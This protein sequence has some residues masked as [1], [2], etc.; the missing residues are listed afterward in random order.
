M[1][2]KEDYNNKKQSFNVSQ[3]N[4]NIKTWNLPISKKMLYIIL[5]AIF[6]QIGYNLLA[7]LF[8]FMAEEKKISE[9]TVGMIF[10][11]FAI[12]NLLLTVLTPYLT[13]IMGRQNLFILGVLIEGSCTCWFGLL[14][15]INHRELFIF[16]SFTVRLLQGAGA[17][18]VQT[19]IYSLTASISDDSNMEKNFGYIEI[20][21]SIG[22]ALGPLFASIGYYMFGFNFPFLISGFM[23]LCLIL[24][25]SSLE[26]K[27]DDDDDEKKE[28][29]FSII[30]LILNRNIILT[31]VASMMDSISIS[32]TY[33]V[34]AKHLSKNYN[35]KPEQTSLFFMIVTIAYFISLQ[36]LGYINKLLGN[37]VT[38]LLGTS[39]NGFFILFLGPSKFL[40]SNIYIVVLGLIGLGFA[41]A[42]VTIPAIIE[43]IFILTNEI[44]LEESTCQDLGSAIFNLGQYLGE[45]IG[46]LIGGYLVEKN[47]FILGC[48]YNSGYN[49]LFFLIYGFFIIYD[50]IFL[51]KKIF[52]KITINNNNNLT[53]KIDDNNVYKILPVE[54]LE[55]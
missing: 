16:L 33:P 20:G 26:I 37:R 25:V 1:N 53:D 21:I 39:F 42:F 46:P 47:G 32:F 31:F 48:Q 13:H 5:Y 45:T 49:F 38:I 27:D 30:H 2:N 9:S 4:K 41:G 50:K 28:S 19:L 15:F 7:P 8:P 44:K 52:G 24:L 18:I 11:S 34:F 35:L 54:D 12:S 40:P 55:K 6:S 22:I 10:S 17:A 43:I 23:E 14:E 29:N 36:F 51:K 3:I